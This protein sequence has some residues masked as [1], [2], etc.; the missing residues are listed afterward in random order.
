MISSCFEFYFGLLI[1]CFNSCSLSYLH[2]SITS[3]TFLSLLGA[4]V[5]IGA[6]LIYHYRLISA[7][8]TSIEYHI[9]KDQR[10]KFAAL[11]KVGKSKPNHQQWFFLSTMD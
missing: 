9:N 8:E 2:F 1:F 11:N 6:L 4:F 7:G 10:K 5:A 3:N